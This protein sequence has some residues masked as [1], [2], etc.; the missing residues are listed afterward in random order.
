MGLWEELGAALRLA[1]G[2]VVDFAPPAS[3][4]E[5]ASAAAGAVAAA[6]V[7]VVAAVGAAVNGARVV[8]AVAVAVA[9]AEP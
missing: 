2:L 4:V 8:D 3:Q 1:L 9:E 6:V 5:G 7:V